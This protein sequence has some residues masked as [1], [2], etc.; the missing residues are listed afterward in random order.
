M[1]YIYILS[2][3]ISLFICNS[4]F[5][6]S[7]TIPDQ[8]IDEIN[9]KI[10]SLKQLHVGSQTDSLG[11]DLLYLVGSKNPIK[12]KLLEVGTKTI[13]FIDNNGVNYNLTKKEVKFVRTSDGRTMNFNID[14]DEDYTSSEK[15]EKDSGGLGAWGIIGIVLTSLIILGVIANASK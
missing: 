4:S 3:F 11:K 10:S 9:T 7:F 14:E 12:G 13:S 1:R 8:L 15:V 5:G 2:F 6:Q